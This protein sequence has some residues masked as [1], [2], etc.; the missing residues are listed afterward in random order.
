M[1]DP[2]GFLHL[3]VNF[4]RN[5]NREYYFPGYVDPALMTPPA[6]TCGDSGRLR[7]IELIRVMTFSKIRQLRVAIGGH[8]FSDQSR[9]L[10]DGGKRGRDLFSHDQQPRTE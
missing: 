2:C 6:V 10:I 5:Q 4:K 9:D 1:I 7:L 8:S 3:K